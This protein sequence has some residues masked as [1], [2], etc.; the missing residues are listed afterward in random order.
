MLTFCS[1]YV[2]SYV[3]LSHSLM[4]LWKSKFRGLPLHALVDIK[5]HLSQTNCISKWHH[6]EGIL[7]S[8]RHV[9]FIFL[10]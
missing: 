7:P 6:T 3:S 8:L 10:F 9:V 2:L 5:A 4:W 1:V